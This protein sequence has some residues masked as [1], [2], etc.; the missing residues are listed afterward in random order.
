MNAPKIFSIFIHTKNNVGKYIIAKR[1]KGNYDIFFEHDE[2]T[3]EDT[4]VK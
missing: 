1:E 2:V 4:L 3:R